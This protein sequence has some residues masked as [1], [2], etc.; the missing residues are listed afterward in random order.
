VGLRALPPRVVAPCAP[1]PRRAESL[2]M[3]RRPVM[4]ALAVVAFGALV[5]LLLRFL[6]IQK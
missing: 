6:L 4:D 5:L 1:S 2:M 3:M